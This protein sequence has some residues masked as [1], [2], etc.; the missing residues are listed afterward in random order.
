MKEITTQNSFNDHQ[1]KYILALN[2]N[3]KMK[4]QKPQIYYLLKELILKLKKKKN[5]LGNAIKMIEDDND[6]IKIKKMLDEYK[7]KY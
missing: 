7:I 4:A 1:E 5:S 2:E 3:N 6:A